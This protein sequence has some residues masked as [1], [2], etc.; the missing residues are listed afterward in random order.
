MAD[1]ALDTLLRIGELAA[2]C[3]ERLLEELL[4]DVLVEL[5]VLGI[6]QRPLPEDADDVAG[7]PV[8][9]L[10]LAVCGERFDRYGHTGFELE[11]VPVVVVRH[12]E[13]CVE[14][15]LGDLM[16]AKIDD[17][18][19]T[20]SLDG[21]LHRASDLVEGHTLSDEFSH[22]IPGRLADL[23]EF[24]I[25]PGPYL[26]GTCG[27]SDETVQYASAVDLDDVPDL[28]H[29]LVI[30]TGGGVRRDLVPAD[31]AWEGELASVLADVSLHLLC[32]IVQLHS[33]LA[34]G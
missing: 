29:S 1:Q 18:F 27:V 11:G 32:D 17:G 8:L 28:E 22:G 24:W 7:L 26:Y 12:G 3:A 19:E 14:E 10:P 6:R 31:V 30:A 33:G 4:L 9:D 13:S 2:P 20:C 5:L 25:T 34:H 23:H 15:I 16:A 21:P